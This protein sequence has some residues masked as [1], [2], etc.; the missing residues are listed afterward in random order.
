MAKKKASKRTAAKKARKPNN[1]PAITARK[2]RQGKDLGGRPPFK[3]NYEQLEKLCGIF[4][5]GE[6]CAAILG[7]SYQTLNNRLREDWQ[8]AKTAC[9]KNPSPKNEE[10]LAHRANGFREYFARFSAHGRVT[11][12]QKQF[13][14]ATEKQGNVQMLKHLGN[15]YLDQ[16]H[17]VDHTSKGEKIEQG[18]AHPLADLDFS[19][20]SK[21]EFEAF[22]KMLKKA[23]P[24]SVRGSQT[25]SE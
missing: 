3:I 5:P 7:C 4:T 9:D 20:L 1:S 6:D 24:V 25:E 2:R 14:V 10:L 23:Q 22:G 12:R 18:G 13:R 8:Q 21:K 19:K 17:R 15:N 16:S 11:L